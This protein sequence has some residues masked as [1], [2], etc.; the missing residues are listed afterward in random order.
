MWVLLSILIVASAL[1]F[2]D[3]W[4]SW[5]ELVAKTLKI[6]QKILC[7]GMIYIEL[8][9]VDLGCVQFNPLSFCA[10][11]L[12]FNPLLLLLIFNWNNLFCH[13]FL[14]LYISPFLDQKIKFEKFS[15]LAILKTWTFWSIFLENFKFLKTT[16]FS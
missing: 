14:Y 11:W 4:L 12:P 6:P 15:F 1:F 8:Q 7:R 9:F 2:L 13:T 16:S 5:K 10:I 3:R